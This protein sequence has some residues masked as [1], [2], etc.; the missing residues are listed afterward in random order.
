MTIARDAMLDGPPP[1]CGDGMGVRVNF[2]LRRSKFTPPLTPPGV[3]A[4]AMLR[5]DGEGNS[6]GM[7]RVAR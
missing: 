4:L 1:P 3:M 2:T 6:V 5:M 7:W